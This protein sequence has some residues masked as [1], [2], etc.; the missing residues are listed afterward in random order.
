MSD[1]RRGSLVR[2][3]IASDGCV[4]CLLVQ[5]ELTYHLKAA[6]TLHRS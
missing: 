3:R 5:I 6:L 2:G 4:A 1:A